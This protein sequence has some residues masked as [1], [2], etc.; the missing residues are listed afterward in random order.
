MKSDIKE[1]R[2]YYGHTNLWGK[3]FCD[4]WVPTSGSNSIPS[5]EGHTTNTGFIWYTKCE[6]FHRLNIQVH[7]ALGL[8]EF[9]AQTILKKVAIYI[10]LFFQKTMAF[11]DKSS[12]F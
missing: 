12:M 3:Y 4:K 7:L 8:M 11:S 6:I 9:A 1:L 5:S 2:F 10:P